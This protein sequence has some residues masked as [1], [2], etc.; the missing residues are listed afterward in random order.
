LTSWKVFQGIQTGADAYTKR[1]DRRLTGADRS[2]LRA[3][4]V[5]IGDPILERPLSHAALTPWVDHPDVVVRSP[6]P[7]ALLYGAIDGADATLL[8]VIRDE[9]TP[10]VLA[11]LEPARP[12]LATRA[13]IARNARRKWFEAAWPRSRDEMEA[14]KVIALYRTDRGPICSGRGG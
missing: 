2:R 3:D 6:E 12:I 9:P 10:D 13:E 1:I 4:A 14:P 7:R 8:V 5:E 11:A